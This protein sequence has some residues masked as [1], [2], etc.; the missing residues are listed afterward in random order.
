MDIEHSRLEDFDVDPD[1][2]EINDEV[3]E[4][5]D[6]FKFNYLSNPQDEDNA[7]IIEQKYATFVKS[8]VE[9][10]YID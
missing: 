2:E 5:F 7:R 10:K 8:H 1:Y 3:D 9:H 4:Y 6:L